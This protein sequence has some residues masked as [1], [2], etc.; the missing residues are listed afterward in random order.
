MKRSKRLSIL[1]GVLAVC[2]VLTLGVSK[3]EERKEKIKNSDEIIME[4]NSEDVTELSWEYESETL[5]FHKDENWLYD[6][7]EHFPVNEEK[8]NQ[9][10]ENFRSF[11]VS[12][13]IE[14]AEDLSQYGL[15]DPLCTIHI[16]L[17][18]GSYE[19]SLGNYSEMDEER[20]VSIGDG[21][22]YL[23]KDDP[24]DSFDI[25]L[26]D[27]IQHDEI[28]EIDSVT[29]IQFAGSENYK[30]VYK[31]DNKVTYSKEDIYFVKEGSKELP[32]DT[33]NVENYVETIREL[34]LTNYVSYDVTEEELKSYGMDSPELTVSL[35]YQAGDGEDEEEKEEKVVLRISRD[36]AEKEKVESEAAKSSDRDKSGEDTE[37]DTDEEIT[38][39]LR[40]GESKI[41]YQISEPDYED[42]MDASYNALR[43]QEVIWADFEDISG[44]KISLEEAEYEL[45]VKEKNKES[46]WYYQD[47]EIETDDFRNAL[48]SLSASEFTEEKPTDKEEI[49]LTL[50][51][52]SENQPEVEI[53]LYRY[54]GNKCLAVVDGEP[55]SLVNRG[56]VVDLIEAVNAIVLN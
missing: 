50:Q 53:E 28:P 56:Y 10:I 20:Y 37:T 24:L 41:I 29:E 22:V 31:E 7:D 6:K 11:G 17:K 48:N 1:L 5:A 27:M 39:Y 19:I 38:A 2:C 9:L 13:I 45:I 26:N 51:I 34:N 46:I 30:A 32:L 33:E 40:I 55:V 4:L 42:L 18:E 49:S 36:P 52:N 14:D 23:V 16:G 25:E 47:N 8:I 15:S 12:F 43:H 54:D 21:N 3:Y 44:V 35:Q